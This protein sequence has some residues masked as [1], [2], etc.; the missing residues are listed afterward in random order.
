M[1]VVFAMRRNIYKNKYATERYGHQRAP[2]SHE[3]SAH[4]FLGIL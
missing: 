4:D 3:D 2:R 1:G